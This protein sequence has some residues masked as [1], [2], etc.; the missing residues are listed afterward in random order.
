MLDPTYSIIRDSLFAPAPAELP[1]EIVQYKGFYAYR[2][3]L[4]DFNGLPESKK[5][6]FAEWIHARAKA[7]EKLT[8]VRVTIE[9][10]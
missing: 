6:N 4:D 9:W 10:E 3:S 8:G 2:F 1:I 5:T 7:A